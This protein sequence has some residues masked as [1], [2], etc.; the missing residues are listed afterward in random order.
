M[1]ATLCT[2]PA[3]NIPTGYCCG[4]VSYKALQP[5]IHQSSVLWLQQRHV[6]AKQE[7]TGREMAAE[8]FLSVPLSYLMGSLTCRK[9]LR[10]GA[11]NYTSHPKEVV[12]R[13]LLPL[14]IHHSWP[15]LKAQ[16]LGPMANT[17][18]ISSPNTVLQKQFHFRFSL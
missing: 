8:I 9:I 15:D 5:F 7:E 16:T 11:K 10:H 18:T 3:R 4:L 12:L 13:I 1:A 17:I 14:K 6:A 2:I